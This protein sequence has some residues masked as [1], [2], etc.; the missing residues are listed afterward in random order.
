M[1]KL[2]LLQKKFSYGNL[3]KKLVFNVSFFSSC[4]KMREEIENKT[5]RL[6]KPI[7]ARERLSITFRFFA[8][9][10]TY[11]SLRYQYRLSPSSISSIVPEVCD[12][13]MEAL[14]CKYMRFPSNK[15][16]FPHCIGAI[17]GKHIA[18]SNPVNN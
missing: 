8:A 10:E 18:F 4:L 16:E 9:R 13:I 6:R 3:R 7:S 11:R 12:A 14:A 2:I 17:D 5:T 15:E 1:L